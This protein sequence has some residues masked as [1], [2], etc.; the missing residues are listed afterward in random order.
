MILASFTIQVPPQEGDSKASAC[1]VY[2]L[3]SAVVCFAKSPHKARIR[4]SW[5]VRPAC[6]EISS[7]LSTGSLCLLKKLA[8]CYA[9][10]LSLSSSA[11][12]QQLHTA[13]TS[14]GKNNTKQTEKTS[15]E[16]SPQFFKG[17]PSKTYTSLVTLFCSVLY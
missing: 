5:S 17:N 10:L 2:F 15:Q 7:K 13:K 11:E 1:L 9:Q 14:T 3:E 8:F 12:S 16:W 6:T 4:R